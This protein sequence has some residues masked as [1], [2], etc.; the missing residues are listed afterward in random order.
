MRIQADNPA[1]LSGGA[2]RRLRRLKPLGFVNTRTLCETPELHIKHRLRRSDKTIK[3]IHYFKVNKLKAELQL[4]KPVFEILHSDQQWKVENN[5][6][7]EE[8]ILS[9]LSF[10]SSKISDLSDY[11]GT[12]RINKNRNQLSFFI[13]YIN[14][15][16]NYSKNTF[17]I[18]YLFQFR[19]SVRQKRRQRSI[20]GGHI[21]TT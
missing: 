15:L 8:E 21:R 1:R 9:I 17:E 19:P 3:L 18:K 12:I 4:I 14:H 10:T 7:S 2:T 16:N 20:S 11:I 6:C 13:D 5:D